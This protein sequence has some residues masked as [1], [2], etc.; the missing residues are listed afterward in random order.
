MTTF[1]AFQPPPNNAF[2]FQPTLDGNTCTAVV[3]WNADAQRW[4]VSV[5]QPDGTQLF[6]VPLIGSPIG[7]PLQALT[8]ANGIATATTQEPHGYKFLD[9]VKLTVS[10]CQ[11]VPYNGTFP[12]FI[13]GESTFTYGLPEHPDG[14]NAMEGTDTANQ[15]GAVSY[16]INMGAGYLT[17]STFVFRESTQMFEISP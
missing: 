8:W 16:D 10:G 4:F 5:S 7:T 12:C 9:T 2:S 15:L 11:P 13:I 3:W 1:T 6:N 14:A 17:E